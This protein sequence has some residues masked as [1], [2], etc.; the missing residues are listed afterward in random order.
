MGSPWKIRSSRDRCDQAYT[1]VT[2]GT[3]SKIEQHCCFGPKIGY[4]R[5]LQGIS[6]ISLKGENALPEPQ[7]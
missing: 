7:N 1:V 3:S 6:M 5:G 4:F 2:F